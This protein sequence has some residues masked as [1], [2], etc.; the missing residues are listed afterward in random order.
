MGTSRSLQVGLGLFAGVGQAGDAPGFPLTVEQVLHAVFVHVVRETHVAECWQGRAEA[1]KVV[2][3]RLNNDPVVMG[4]R[5][6]TVK[7]SV[8]SWP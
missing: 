1:L 8:I 5:R 3:Q 2:S 6:Q 7:A 4:Q